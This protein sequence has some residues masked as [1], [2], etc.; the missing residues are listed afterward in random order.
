M[1]K[2]GVKTAE[3]EVNAADLTAEQCVAAVWDA[4]D[5]NVANPG[6]VYVHSM[7]RTAPSPPPP[8]PYLPPTSFFSYIWFGVQL[9]STHAAT[10]NSTRGLRCWGL[11]LCV[12]STLSLSL[13]LSLSC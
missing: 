2:Q 9:D 5:A 7:T 4:F 13:S 1:A 6:L 8:P 10:R 11:S 12:L 3:V